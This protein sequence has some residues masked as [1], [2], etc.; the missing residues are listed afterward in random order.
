MTLGKFGSVV[1][2]LIVI[3]STL[4][5][6]NASILTGSRVT[7]VSAQIGHAPHIFSEIHEDTNTPV[8]ALLFQLLFS[9]F[10]IIYGD[11]QTLINMYSMIAWVFYFISVFGLCIMR[12]TEP[13][14]PRPFKVWIFCPILF[15][16]IS[17]S[18]VAFSFWEA[19]MEGFL[20]LIFLASGIIIFFMK[21]VLS[22][23][24]IFPKLFSW[25]SNSTSYQDISESIE[26]Q[27]F[28]GIYK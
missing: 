15:C 14:A 16:I 1:I 28:N 6:A 26:L 9:V 11:F 22:S 7:F 4:G 24:I 19:P 25:T 23:F 27:H 2:P 8:N 3:F 12:V 17:A 20:A 18:L 10:L 21:D 5:A 13:F